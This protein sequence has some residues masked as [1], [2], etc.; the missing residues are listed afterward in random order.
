[1][2]CADTYYAGHPQ[3]RDLPGAERVPRIAWSAETPF[4]PDAP[5]AGDPLP[6]E[7]N[8]GRWIVRCDQCLSAQLASRS[9]P[10]FMCVTCGNA[11]QGGAWRPIEWPE[12]HEEIGRLLDERTDQ[13]LANA[14]AGESAEDIWDQNQQLAEREGTVE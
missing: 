14:E 13:R 10:R 6:V 12:D 7:A 8:H 2:R 1:M 5:V 3:V 9:D 4:N 11:D